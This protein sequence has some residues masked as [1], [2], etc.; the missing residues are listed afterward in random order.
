MRLSR[1]PTLGPASVGYGSVTWA[2]INLHRTEADSPSTASS[3]GYSRPSI[4]GLRMSPADELYF[5]VLGK[6]HTVASG[7]RCRR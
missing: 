5:S 3:R 4:G 1:G 7:G 6:K 2:D